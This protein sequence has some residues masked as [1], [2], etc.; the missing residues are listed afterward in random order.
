MKLGD[1][2][3]MGSKV[4]EARFDYEGNE[5]VFEWCDLTVKEDIEVSN[6]TLKELS[7]AGIDKD[8]EA[9]KFIIVRNNIWARIN[10]ADP[11]QIS[12]VDFKENL[13]MEI[14]AKV[15]TTM[16]ESMKGVGEDF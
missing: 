5:I 11:N 16:A 12:E 7:D 9:G 15:I 2:G 13:L 6:A 8:S 14:Q 4:N 1:L 3:N 10:K